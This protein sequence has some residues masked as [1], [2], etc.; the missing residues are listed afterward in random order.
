[1]KIWVVLGV[2]AG[3][4]GCSNAYFQDRAVKTAASEHGCG[5]VAI[6][7]VVAE[8][9]MHSDFA[10]WLNVCGKERL[11]RMDATTGDRFVDQTKA[12]Q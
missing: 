12:V 2:S 1:M 11:Y 3:A 9:R 7:R 4:I 8:D 5:A 6:Q 10:Y